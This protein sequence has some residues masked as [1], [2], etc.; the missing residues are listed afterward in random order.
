MSDAYAAVG[1]VTI[2]MYLK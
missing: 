2:N 1:S